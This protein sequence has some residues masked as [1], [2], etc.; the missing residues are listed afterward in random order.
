MIKGNSNKLFQRGSLIVVIILFGLIIAKLFYVAVSPTVDGVDLKAFALTRTTAVKKV[1][2]SRGTI[3]DNMGEVLAQDVRS[4]TVIA[5][6]D[7]SRTTDP[8]KPYHVVDKQRTADLLSPIINMSSEDILKLL[9]RNAYQVELGPGGRGIT[10]LVKQEIEALELPGID[11]I[12]SSK[13]DYPYGDFASYIIGYAKKN[14]DGDIVGELGIEGKYDSKLKGTD[15][16]II[17]QKD[18]YGYKIAGTP[19]Y[20]EKAE[21]GVDIY[22]TLDSNIQMYLENAMAKIEKD[23]AEWASITIADTKTGAIVGSSSIPSFNPNILNITNYNSQLSS[24]TY[25]PGSTMK[26][27]SFMAA[28]EEGIYKGDDLYNSG[29]IIVDDFKISDWNTTGWGKITYDVGFTYSSNVAAV[30]LAQALGKEKLLSYYEKF[31]FGEKTGIELA[32]E[33]SGKVEA[34]YESELASISFGQG[35]TTTPIQNIQALT[36]LANDGVVLKPYLISKIVDPNTGEI[37]YEATR[38]ELGRAV[39]SSTV[40]KMIELMDLTVNGEDKAA[41]GKRYATES[42]RLIGKT[43]TAQYALSNGKYSSGTYNNVRSFAGMFPKDDPKYVIY[44]SAKKYLGGGSGLA[45]VVKDVVESIAKYKNLDQRESDKD[46]SK[47]I[48]IENYINKDASKIVTNLSNSGANVVVI[49]N[50]DKIVSQYPSKGDE[51]LAG[52]R[53]FLVTN[54]TEVQ[55][56][57]IIGWNSAD[58]RTF[59]NL[60]KIPYTINDYGKVTASSIAEGTVIDAN[61]NLEVTLGGLYGKERVTE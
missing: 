7:S 37:V 48:T 35:M 46:L 27:Y 59:A 11:F 21:S 3:Y 12:K 4:Y 30:N 25:E 16:K 47:I 2:A 55:M 58:V 51:L 23:G 1:S 34:Y 61:S 45:N 17:Y 36:S 24:F 44:I 43:G 14:D 22:L 42:V 60:V 10:E 5:Y 29:S 15:G 52:N 39:S 18:A 9:N 57:N 32:N 41:T 54:Y 38:H 49:G 56:P 40:S 13:R 31:G 28:I 26:I 6:L 19:E 33:Y 53:L 50:G 8:D 20:E